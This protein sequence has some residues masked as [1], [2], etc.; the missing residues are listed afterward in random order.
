MKP[1]GRFARSCFTIQTKNRIGKMKHFT[2]SRFMN[3]LQDHR[4]TLYFKNLVY[5]SMKFQISFHRKASMLSI[6]HK[7]EK[8]M[9]ITFRID[10]LNRNS[11]SFSQVKS[12]TMS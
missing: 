1:K 6:L 9:E 11:V 12:W 2:I 5:E 10:F 7:R 3:E 8:N 4:G